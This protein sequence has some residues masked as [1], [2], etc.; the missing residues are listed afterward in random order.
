M[1]ISGLASGFD[2]EKMVSDLMQAH[3]IPMDKITQKKQYLEWQLD[4]YRSTN[5]Q[6]FDFSKKTFD[7]MILSTSFAAKTVNISSLNDVAIRNMGSTSDFSGT[8]KVTQLAENATLQSGGKLDLAAGK[9]EST[10][11]LSDMGITGT[12]ISL[13]IKAPGVDAKSLVFNETDSL[14][15]VLDRI[16]KETGVN[17]FYDA[18]TGK[19]AMTAKNSGAGNI[20]V[21]GNLGES[22]GLSTTFSFQGGTSK[23]STLGDLNIDATKIQ[24]NK[25]DGTVETL[26]FSSINTLGYVLKKFN[27]RPSENVSLTD[28]ILPARSPID[29]CV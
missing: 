2:T 8:I 15:T 6:L 17:A 14:K 4:D 27:E 9:T 28:P 25:P 29:F 22:L 26:T 10:T 21:T 3:R 11:L 7:T 13:T 5:R 1:R 12:P 24:V 16:N 20:E 18:H 19:I 23:T